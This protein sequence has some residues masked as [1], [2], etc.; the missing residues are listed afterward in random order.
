MKSATKFTFDTEFAAGGARESH[1]A[2]ARKKRL[3]TQ[4]EIDEL[5]AKAH[6]DGAQSAEVRAQEAIAAAIRDLSGA[7]HEALMRATEDVENLRAESAH[8]AF[9]IAR[10][11]AR[12]ALAE[13]PAEEVEAALREAM[14]QAFGEP[15]IV[16]R[17]APGVAE[18]LKPKLSGI[19][20]DEGFEGRVQVSEEPHLRHVDCRIEWRGGG[21][22][23]AQ[24]A[25]ERAL[26]DIIARRFGAPEQAQMPEQLED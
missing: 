16:L 2:L 22:E 23:R 4:A 7:L 12:A 9:A 17:A 18:A 24:A 13:F 21:A 15:R 25:I 14:H 20:H 11:L 3:L 6:A 1:A 26:Q 19:A 5:C 10:K 8:L